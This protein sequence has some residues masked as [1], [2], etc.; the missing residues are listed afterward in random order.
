V[1]QTSK[2]HVEDPGGFERKETGA[3]LFNLKGGWFLK[4]SL[5][6]ISK[7]SFDCEKNILGTPILDSPVVIVYNEFLNLGLNKPL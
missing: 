2:T 6:S 4:L 1:A 3:R 7:H 5:N